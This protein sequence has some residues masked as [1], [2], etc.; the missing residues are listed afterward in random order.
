MCCFYAA[1]RY[2]MV[3]V[4]GRDLWIVWMKSHTSATLCLLMATMDPHK[5]L[6]TL[7]KRHFGFSSFRPLQREIVEDSLNGKD[8]VALLPTGGG[9]SLCYQLRAMAAEGLTLVISP[10]IALMKDQ[11]DAMSELGIPATF[12]NSSLTP[13]ESLERRRGLD[14][15]TYKLLYIAPERL[16]MEGMLDQLKRWHLAFVAIDEAHCI[17][18]WGHD[19]RP[20]YRQ[21]ASVRARFPEVPVMALTATATQRVRDDIVKLLELRDSRPYVASFNRPNLSYRVIAR[22]QPLEQIVEVLDAHKGESGIIYCLSRARTE[23]VAKA[24]AE[25]G[26]KACAYHAGLTPEE[27]TRR[28]EHFV[29]DKAP[30]IAA[31]IAFG[32]G[33]D[34]PDVRFVIHHDLPKNLEGYYQETGRAGRDGLPSECVLLYSPSDYAKLIGFIEEISDAQEKESARAHLGK[35]MRFAESA[36]CR[37]IELLGYFGETYANEGGQTLDSCGA[38]DNCLT[39][40]ES[41]DGS[42]EAQKILSCALRIH[43]KSGFSVGLHHLVDV[44]CGAK[45][46]KIRKFGH[47][48]LSTYGIG[49][50]HG[51]A[52]W[53]AYAQELAEKGLLVVRTDKFNI[54]EVTD[55]GLEAL[56]GKQT[57]ML[58]RPLVS[59]K[60]STEQRH[61]QRQKTGAVEVATELF[62][63]LRALRL[64]LARERGLPAYMVF[65]DATLQAMAALCPQSRD[66]MLDVVGVGEKKLAQYGDSFIEILR[67][68]KQRKT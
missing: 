19:F 57:V 61:K 6:L 17:S 5:K 23:A 39:P 58:R 32:M 38:C 50:G 8:V 54:A 12:L 43:R 20:E 49:T 44:L 15:G 56:R 68:W 47:E 27:R 66:E 4:L 21:L 24:L 3:G 67:G 53:L 51:R 62:E 37:R 34:K 63:E 1:W 55:K 2:V 41:F 64:R 30:I 45:T 26:F 10:L 13:E 36:R 28:Q 29:N 31:T 60:L 65:S 25:R 35:M 59:A 52:A 14:E 33:I 9:K 16:V 11:V 48:T 7:L 18:E 42:E 40:R 46:E 22:H